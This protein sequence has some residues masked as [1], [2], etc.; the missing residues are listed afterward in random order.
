[1]EPPEVSTNLEDRGARQRCRTVL[2]PRWAALC[3]PQVSEVGGA[4]FGR[5]TDVG[6]V[7]QPGE[8]PLFRESGAWEPRANLCFRR[9]IEHGGGVCDWAAHLRDRSLDG[10]RCRALG[11]C[12]GHVQEDRRVDQAVDPEV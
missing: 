5:V 1:M 11:C 8:M 10:P 4:C 12:S 7:L 3:G 9:G 2:G 6:V